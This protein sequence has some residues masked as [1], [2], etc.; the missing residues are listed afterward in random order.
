MATH[1]VDACEDYNTSGIVLDADFMARSAK[2]FRNPYDLRPGEADVRQVDRLNVNHDAV[3]E[4]L[5]IVGRHRSICAGAARKKQGMEAATRPFHMPTWALYLLSWRFCVAQTLVDVLGGRRPV[6]EQEALRTAL[7]RPTCPTC[8]T[9]NRLTCRRRWKA[10]AG[11]QRR[12]GITWQGTACVA[13][14]E[15]S[16]HRRIG[17]RRAAR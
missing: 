17:R 11:H 7:P 5:E 3:L 8:W 9:R 12:Q 10:P 16:L 4:N 13:S 15:L 14:G 1:G 6:C 2:P